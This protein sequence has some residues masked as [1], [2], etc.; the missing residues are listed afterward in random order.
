MKKGYLNLNYDEKLNKESIEME[1]FYLNDDQ[2]GGDFHEPMCDDGWWCQGP[3]F[4]YHNN[5]SEADIISSAN[6]CAPSLFLNEQKEI[7]GCCPVGHKGHEGTTGLYEEELVI[8]GV[9]DVLQDTQLN[10]A[11]E[12]ARIFLAREI[13]KDLRA[14]GML[15]DEYTQF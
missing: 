4:G 5:L 11:S 2:C 7:K 8:K 3:P 1:V 6:I 12:Q 15:K 13:A 9:L 10:M 14:A